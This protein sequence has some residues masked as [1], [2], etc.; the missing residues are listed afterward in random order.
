MKETRCGAIAIT[1]AMVCSASPSASKTTATFARISIECF[2]TALPNPRRVFLGLSFPLFFAHQPGREQ[3]AAHTPF[4]IA[5]DT[6]RSP[7]RLQPS[8]E[9]IDHASP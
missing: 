4:T 7:Q 2:S 8:G 5:D 1:R 3:A 6:A 9:V